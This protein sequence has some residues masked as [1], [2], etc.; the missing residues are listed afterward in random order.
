MS[1]VHCLKCIYLLRSPQIRDVI[2]ICR[3]WGLKS[4]NKIPSFIVQSS[5]GHECPF[6]TEKH[7]YDNKSDSNK[8]NNNF[9]FFV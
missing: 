7:N 3:R 8:K 6:Y 1:E 2:F 5:I 9:D 4:V